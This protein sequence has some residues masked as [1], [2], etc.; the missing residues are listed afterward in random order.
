[1]QMSGHLNAHMPKMLPVLVFVQLA[2]LAV[3][4]F[5]AP[6][7]QMP[8][9][10]AFRDCEGCPEMVVVPAGSFT[11]GSP[12]SEPDR[13]A[14]EGPQHRVTFARPLAVAKYAITRSEFAR[15]VEASGYRVPPG[16]M[17]MKAGR[18][19]DHRMASWRHPGF[20]QTDTDPVVCVNWNDAVAYAEWLSHHSGHDYAL[21]TEAEWEYAARAGTSTPHYWGRTPS[22]DFA[23]YGAD[24]CCGP[25]AAGKDRWQYTSPAGSFPPNA[26]GL[27]DMQGNTWEWVQDCWHRNYE[28]APH[29]GT[30][31]TRE[32]CVD[33]VLRGG[34]WMCPGPF[35]RAAVRELHDLS[36]RFDF[37]GFRVV[38]R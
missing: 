35:Q 24:R 32:S 13:T 15:F 7:T 25:A 36:G 2:A 17:I 20:A 27:Y 6:P 21:P 30:A 33:R 14:D 37:V 3:G 1:M 31:W 11:M 34:A 23:N 12:E 10:A 38:R 4:A 8:A 9:G 18:W 29:D 19:S 5:A 22:H 26:F 28:G 16:C